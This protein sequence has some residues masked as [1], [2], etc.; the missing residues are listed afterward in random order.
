MQLGQKNRTSC[1]KKVQRCSELRLKCSMSW[2]EQYKM[3]EK[4]SNMIKTKTKIQL[5]AL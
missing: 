3:T 5:T 1:R 2:N 4:A